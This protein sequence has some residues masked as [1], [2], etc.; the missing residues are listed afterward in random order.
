LIGDLLAADAPTRLPPFET[1]AQSKPPLIAGL[2]HAIDEM[3]LRLLPDSVGRHEMN[4][5]TA[6][7]LPSG[8]W[9]YEAANGGHDDTVIARA[10]MWHALAGAGVAYGSLPTALEDYRGG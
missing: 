2:H 7:Q 10:L 4:I 9:R 5:F 3:G 8:A 1:T 6:S